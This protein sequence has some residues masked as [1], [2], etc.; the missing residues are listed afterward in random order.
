MQFSGVT[1][2]RP[3]RILG[4]AQPIETSTCEDQSRRLARAA[5]P[6]CAA[7]YLDLL[8]IQDRRGRPSRTIV[9]RLQFFAACD[10]V[11]RNTAVAHV[12]SEGR[13]LCQGGRIPSGVNEAMGPRLRYRLAH[14][15]AHAPRMPDS[16]DNRTWL[17]AGY[18]YR[19]SVREAPNRFEAYPARSLKSTRSSPGPEFRYWPPATLRATIR[20]KK[21]R[22]AGSA[23]DLFQRNEFLDHATLTP[24]SARDCASCAGRTAPGLRPP[25]PSRAGTVSRSGTPARGARRSGSARVGGDEHHRHLEGAEQFVDGVEA[26]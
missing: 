20:C 7:R 6:H 17:I 10:G 8:E 5:R 11:A 24:P 2:P 19:E 25:R 18:Q 9:A 12:S 16:P 1:G 3:G 14:K 22:R 23:P 21:I 15:P 26:A 4:G 13:D